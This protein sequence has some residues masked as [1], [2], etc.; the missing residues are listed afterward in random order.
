[1]V[2][3]PD[4]ETVT[5][6]Y[7]IL[8]PPI[9]LQETEAGVFHWS[10]E[11]SDTI[12]I[13]N[14]NIVENS[15]SANKMAYEM[16]SVQ[17]KR[18]MFEE[19]STSDTAA[20]G[21]YS[22][23][24]DNEEQTTVLNTDF[25]HG[26][27]EFDSEPVASSSLINSADKIPMHTEKEIHADRNLEGVRFVELMYFI[28]KLVEISNHIP[29]FGCTLANMSVVREVIRGFSSII[30]FSCN[31]C[32]RTFSVPTHNPSS[33]SY[34]DVNSRAVS[35]IMS[36]GGG[37]S[38]LEEFCATVGVPCMSAMTYSKYHNKVCDGWE[39]A[40]TTQMKEAVEEE[41]ALAKQRGD[42]DE[43]GIPLLTVVV[44]GS[45][46]KR[47]YK[48]KYDALS[49]VAAIVGYETKKVIF[50]AVANKYCY[51]CARTING[52][53][54][55]HV[56]Y[57]NHEGSSSS[58]EANIILEGFQQSEAEHNVKYARMIGDGDSSVYKK[59]L[60]AR[61]YKNITVEKI[62]CRN[63]LL[64]NYRRKLMNVS[65]NSSLGIAALRKV[66]CNKISKIVSGVQKAVAYRKTENTIQNNRIQGLKYD[67]ENGTSHVFGEHL[68]CRKLGYFCNNRKEGEINYV[69]ELSKKW[70]VFSTHSTQARS[71]IFDVDNNAA[72][73]F[74]S[75]IAKF[76]GGKCINYTTRRSY[77]GRCA[78]A[79]VAHNTRMP[80]YILHKTMQDGISPNKVAKKLELKRKA[81][82][83][84]RRNNK[85]CRRID[86]RKSLAQAIS[87]KDYG[88]QCQKPDMPVDV[89]QQ[90]ETR[91]LQ[92]I[93]KTDEE[94][95]QIERETILQ[96][97][98]GEWLEMRRKLLTASKFGRVIRIKPT[99]SCKNLVRAIIYSH[100]ILNVPAVQHGRHSE[101][102]AIKQL[103]GQEKINISKAGL[104]IDQEHPFLAATPDG[105]DGEDRLVEIKCPASA[106]GMD[107][108]EAMREGKIKY[109]KYS[110]ECSTVIS[111]KKIMN[112][113]TKSRV[114]FT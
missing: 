14:I 45:W 43:F 56:C 109:L 27:N 98:S 54:P 63:H 112:I 23:S 7:A 13:E 46:S 90:E 64:R 51:V 53:I 104:F 88:P 24:T 22:T 55:Q 76:S 34:M 5:K 84:K 3:N 99:T 38:H 96:A 85:K 9:Q 62:E 107:I 65:E 87:D 1:M 25:I 110:E 114:S 106:Y 35:G 86:F 30:V 103:E 37:L 89:Y 57:K 74:N 52:T 75:V 97:G 50:M 11:V 71:L 8:Q 32:N 10:T 44:D 39:K 113:S 80:H 18:K 58:M 102:I 16:S 41:A 69:P 47:S 94:R 2:L 83:N 70:S 101:E 61:P 33:P 26:S 91:L 73:H 59:I 15:E 100:D 12:I 19:V 31:M 20:K 49:G 108:S 67:I 28:N 79:V 4:E 48:T 93:P 105:L 6:S 17:Q 29:A 68:E 66:V 21:E 42:V 81:R 77:Q 72:E 40:A 95:R 82:I 60:E 36:I 78:A 111:L 92:S